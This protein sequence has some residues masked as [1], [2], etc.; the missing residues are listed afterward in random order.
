MTFG[1]VRLVEVVLEPGSLVCPP[2]QRQ[3]LEQRIR[4]SEACSQPR[5]RWG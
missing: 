4:V 2:P 5:L 1:M 3:P